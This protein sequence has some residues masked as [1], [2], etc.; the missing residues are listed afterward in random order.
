MIAISKI[1]MWI[2]YAKEVCYFVW[3]NI[4]IY[5]VEGFSSALPNFWVKYNLVAFRVPL[6]DLLLE[7]SRVETDFPRAALPFSRSLV[8]LS[9]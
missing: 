5:F 9:C 2:G 6:I 7:L 8:M 1:I 3:G 4:T